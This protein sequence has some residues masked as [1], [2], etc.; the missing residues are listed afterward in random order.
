[1]EDLALENIGIVYVDLVNFMPIWYILCKFGIFLVYV[2][3][4]G[5]LWQE[6]SD[7]PALEQ[8]LRFK[9]LANHH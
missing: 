3:R 9:L 1:M 4:L 8:K 5:V 6:Q 7:R 2:F